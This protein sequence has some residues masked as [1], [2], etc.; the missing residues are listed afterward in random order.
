MA[1]KFTVGFLGALA[2]TI[3]D[4]YR[5]AVHESNAHRHNGE[6]IRGGSIN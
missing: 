3:A 2:A 5:A 6:Y 4:L 1:F